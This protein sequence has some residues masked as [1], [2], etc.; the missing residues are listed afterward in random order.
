MPVTSAVRRGVHSLDVLGDLVEADRV[1]ADEVVIEPVVLDH[2]VQDAVEQ[3]DVAARFDG[4]EQVAGPRQRRDARIDDDDLGAVLARLPDV[5]G[6]DRGAF[7]DVG[8]ADPDRP[9]P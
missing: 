4:Q 6:G 3:G 8:A 2:Q 1:L 5:M 9:W 7:G